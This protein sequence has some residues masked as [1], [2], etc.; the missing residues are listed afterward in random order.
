MSTNKNKKDCSRCN[1]GEGEAF[2]CL[3]NRYVFDVDMAREIIR[4]RDH[5]VMELEP[6]D[7]QYSVNRCEINESHLAHVDP[8]IPG[9]VSHIFFPGDD[10][11]L[12]HGHRLIDGHHRAAR[13][14]Q[15]GIPFPV[16]ILTEEESVGILMK[17]PEGARPRTNETDKAKKRKRRDRKPAGAKKTKVKAR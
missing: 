9:I 16:Q 11:T 6:E 7:V 2:W 13:C 3:K 10:G 12:T 4:N 15:L 14:L 8:S 5:E 1:R 17:A